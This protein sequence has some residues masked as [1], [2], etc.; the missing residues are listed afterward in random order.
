MS[1]RAGT[2]QAE[3]VAAYA[4]ARGS[5]LRT[6]QRHRKQG[7]PDWVEFIKE[8]RVPGKVA[9]I[10]PASMNW[11]EMADLDAD[12]LVVAAMNAYN[13][14]CRAN[15]E[16]AARSAFDRVTKAREQARKDRLSAPKIDL[17][18]GS[19]VPRA[20]VLRYV[21]RLHSQVADSLEEGLVRMGKRI[22]PAVAAVLVRE[23]AREERLRL[24]GVLSDE[25]TLLAAILSGDE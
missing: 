8:G 20:L 9:V 2:D 17:A 13:S 14:A 5:T 23:A 1:D 24:L 10:A 12:P 4:A 15:D 6:A 7:H 16:A 11:S 3:E 19:V 22:A 21:Q 25:D 18:G